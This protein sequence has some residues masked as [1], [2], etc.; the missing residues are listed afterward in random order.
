QWPRLWAGRRRLRPVDRACARPHW[1][2][3]RPFR[4]ARRLARAPL[5]PAGDCGRARSR[6]HFVNVLLLHAFP[7]DERMWEP[8]R[9]AFAER[10]VTTPRLYGRGRTMEAWAVSVAGA[11]DGGL[12]G[13][14]ASVGRY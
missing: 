2:R 1:R 8:P 12:A 6:R 13:L 7:L 4:G 11:V 3:A 9:V 14:G 5:G 10:D